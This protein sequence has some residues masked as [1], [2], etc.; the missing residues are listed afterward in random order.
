MTSG[1]LMANQ[2][3]FDKSVSNMRARNAQKVSDTRQA[4]RDMYVSKVQELHPDDPVATVKAIQKAYS[5]ALKATDKSGK[6]YLESIGSSLPTQDE[7]NII[8]E[9]SRMPTTSEVLGGV[10]DDIP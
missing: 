9:G 1:N 6:A 7:L 2:S 4:K 3:N 10:P 5:P 8:S